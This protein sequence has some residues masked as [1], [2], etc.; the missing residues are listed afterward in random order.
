MSLLVYS[1]ATAAVTR[2]HRLG[3]LKQHTPTIL[4]LW[5]PEVQHGLTSKYQGLLQALREN[6]FTLCRVSSCLLLPP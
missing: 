5:G 1:S 4:R 3:A 2:Y 6:V